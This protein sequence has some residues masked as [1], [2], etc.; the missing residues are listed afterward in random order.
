MNGTGT[1][2]KK[3]KSILKSKES[4]GKFRQSTHFD[5][6][7]IIATNHPPNKDYGF[8][9]IDEP[10]TPFERMTDKDLMDT[11][12]N[13]KKLQEMLNSN[14]IEPTVQRPPDKMTNKSELEHEEFLRK[15]KE[16]YREFDAVRAAR[17][18]IED[19]EDDEEEERV[20]ENTRKNSKT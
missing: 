18:L 6:M 3:V 2:P 8:M 17:K 15:R 20:K 11:E 14:K 9:K 10:K 16:H 5:E 12:P 19:E 1:G 13:D 4:Q 7:N